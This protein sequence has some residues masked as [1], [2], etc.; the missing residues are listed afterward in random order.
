MLRSIGADHVIDYTKEDFSKVKQKYAVIL[1]VILKSSFSK[2]V[3][4]LNENGI[5][6]LTNPTLLKMIRGAWVSRN[7]SRK[8]I[9]EFTNPKVED[10]STLRELIEAG[11]IRAVIDR[12]YTLEQVVE[13]HHYVETGQKKGN[14]VI[15]I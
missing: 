15:S 2:I 12:R 5:Y 4:S 8:V 13:A 9:F 3:K 1:D 11:K 10:L 7:T 6:L 14:V